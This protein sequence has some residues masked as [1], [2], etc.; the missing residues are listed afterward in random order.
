MKHLRGTVY[1]FPGCCGI[2]VV[3]GLADLGDVLVPNQ[4]S[5]RVATT[6]QHQSTAIEAL[7]A[8]GFRE[9]L[10]FTNRNSDNLVTMWARGDFQKVILKKAKKK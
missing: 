7:K 1:A 9:V 5:L 4:Q 8:D 6:T 2:D 3:H 10:T